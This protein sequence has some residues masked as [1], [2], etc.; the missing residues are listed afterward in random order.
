MSGHTT[1][2]A[3]VAEIQAAADAHRRSGRRV[4]NA[5]VA[6]VDAGLSTAVISRALGLS[7]TTTVRWID[8][9]PPDSWSWGQ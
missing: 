8:Q 3:V 5:L 4:H 2:T 1:G 7:Y 9:G 6:A